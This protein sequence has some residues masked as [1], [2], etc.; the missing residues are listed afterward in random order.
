[1]TKRTPTDLSASIRQRLL[2]LAKARGE[3]LQIVLWRYGVERFLYRLGRSNARHRFV[4][5][6]AVLFYL[7]E[8]EPHRPNA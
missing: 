1:M 7:W 3:E 6:G 4:L 2:N 5:K 8:G